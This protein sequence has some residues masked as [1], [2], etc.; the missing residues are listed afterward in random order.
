[1]TTAY[2]EEYDYDSIMHYSSRAF[3]KDYHDP[4]ILTIVPRNGV[5][6]EDIGRKKNYSPKDII[7]IKKMYRCAP[8]ENW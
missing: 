2:G 4:E 6:P 7:K 5:S 8:Y 1:L 3:S